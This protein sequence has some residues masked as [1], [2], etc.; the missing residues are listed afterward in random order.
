MLRGGMMTGD[1]VDIMGNYLLTEDILKIVSN[2][3]SQV[4]GTLYYLIVLMNTCRGY[5]F[6]C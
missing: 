4:E 1:H 2:S 6:E 3:G 5:L